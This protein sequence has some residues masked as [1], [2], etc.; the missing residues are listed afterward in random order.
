MAGCEVV[1][2]A[3]DPSGNVDLDDLAAKAAAHA[4]DLA[5][6][7]VTYPSTHGVFEPNIREVCAIVHEHGGQVYLDGA[8]LNALMGAASPGHF[9]ADVSHLNLHKTFCIPHGGSG[10]AW[11]RSRSGRTSP[12]LPASAEAG[13]RRPVRLRRAR[14]RRHPADLGRSSRSW[15]PRLTEAARVAMLSN[16]RGEAP[17]A[18]PILSHRRGGG[19]AHEMHPRSAG[20]QTTS[21]VTA[22]DIAKQL[23]DLAS[24]PTMSFPVAAR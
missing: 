4:R 7:M 19:V 1:V 9:G 22:E 20:P 10:R 18:A 23:I 14:Q 13:R 3:T 21:G 16:L 24:T 15:G 12:F 17:R 2:V 8:N 6:I 11:G 5:A